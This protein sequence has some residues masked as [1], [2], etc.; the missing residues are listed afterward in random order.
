MRQRHGLLFG[1]PEP[2]VIV[3]DVA[4][5]RLAAEP[6]ANETGV[7]VGALGQLLWRNRVSV[8]HR[9]V[10]P[11]FLT[12]DHIGH[13]G[14]AAHVDDELAH[15]LVQ[16]GFIHLTSTLR[17]LDDTIGADSPQLAD[18]RTTGA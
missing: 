12:E 3:F 1:Q 13:D 11:Q 5:R 10:Q 17:G 8:G 4:A 14:R 18:E 6:L 7:A 9:P 16:F 15:E 2:A